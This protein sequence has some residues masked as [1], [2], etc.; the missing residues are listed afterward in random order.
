VPKALKDKI[1]RVIDANFNRTKEGLR[2]C[3]DICRFV[4]DD[5]SLTQRFKNIRHAITASMLKVGGLSFIKARDM[6]HDRGKSST[7]RELKRNNVPDILYANLQRV[8]E[9]IRVMEE[10][11]K[12]FNQKSA[13]LLKS[14][15]YKIYALE[16][17]IIKKR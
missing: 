13:V 16:Q 6:Q 1:H 17:D 7:H 3:E 9:S 2:V 14:L 8:K 11:T 15:R 12:L 5:A 10:F 4:Y